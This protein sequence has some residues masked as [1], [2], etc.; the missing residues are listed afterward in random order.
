MIKLNTWKRFDEPRPYAVTGGFAFD[1]SGHFPIMFRGPGVRSARNSWSLVTGLHETGL[2]LAEQ[3]AV[4][5]EEELGLEADPSTAVNIGFFENIAPELESHPE[6]T[7]WHWVIHILGVKVKT[8]ET[9]KNKEPQ[10]HPEIKV[11]GVDDLLGVNPWSGGLGE[12]INS[13]LAK[14]REARNSIS[15]F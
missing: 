9:M 11:I 6:E 12:F 10:K 13:H 3:F 5:L 2:T 7:Q 14:I 15:G 4:E 1:G 8:L